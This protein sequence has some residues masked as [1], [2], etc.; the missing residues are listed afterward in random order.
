M[1][2]VR[3]EVPWRE[4]FKTKDRRYR[5]V[6]G[7]STRGA[8]RS[9]FENG[10][11]WWMSFSCHPSLDP[12]EAERREAYRYECGTGIRFWARTCGGEVRE[13]PESEI[14]AGHFMLIGRKDYIRA[15]AVNFKR[16]LSKEWSLNN[17]LV[18]ACRKLDIEDMVLQDA[19]H[20]P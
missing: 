8:S 5:E 10:C 18:A 20:T 12:R 14:R 7:C 2:A 11:G 9:Q 3:P 13:S 1:A 15:S 17:D 16:D 6:P 4:I 19:Q